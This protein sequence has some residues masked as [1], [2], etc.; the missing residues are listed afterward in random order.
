MPLLLFVPSVTCYAILC[1]LTSKAFS[2]LLD[3]C[4]VT[5]EQNTTVPRT[6]SL[7]VAPAIGAAISTIAGFTGHHHGI[8]QGERR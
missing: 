8:K 3:I 7:G 6:S 1:A 2:R 4:D 5:L